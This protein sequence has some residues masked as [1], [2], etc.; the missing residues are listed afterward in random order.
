ML[1]SF[2]EFKFYQSFRVPVEAADDL[3][4][5]VEI[6]ESFD[7]KRYIDD[8]KL[9]DV[10]VTGLGFS[11]A[12]RISVGTELNISLHFKRF[13]IDVS[14]TVV[15]A[16]SD[17]NSEEEIIYGIEIEE[18]K[19]VYKFLEQYVMNFSP[20]RLR[21]CLVDA[22]LK[23]RYTKTSDGFE[24]FSLLLSLF[25]DITKIGENHGFVES[26]LDEVVRILNAQRASIF[27]INPNTNQ[28]EAY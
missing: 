26:M 20:N 5:L 16:F 24:M 7:N 19:K 15:R 11:T 2:S 9:I 21:N 8:A 6:D 25:Q 28:L 17:I 18:D 12:E 22:A 4:F 14:A 23:E 27:L 13:H 10:S 3:R 1:T